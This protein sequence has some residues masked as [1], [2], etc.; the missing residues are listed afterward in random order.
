MNIQVIFHY[1]ALIVSIQVDYNPPSDFSLPSPP[2][3]RPATSVNLR[4][5]A[6]DGTTPLSYSWSPPCSSCARQSSPHVYNIDILTVEEVGTYKCV[7]NDSVGRSGY[8]TTV[9]KL[10]GKPL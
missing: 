6:G 4:C 9:I 1:S 2:Y 10:I 5:I 7:V 8:A 3:Y